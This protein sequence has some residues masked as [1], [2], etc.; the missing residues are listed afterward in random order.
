MRVLF[1]CILF[2]VVVVCLQIFLL[3]LLRFFENELSDKWQYWPRAVAFLSWEPRNSQRR[4]RL[5]AVSLENL[6][7]KKTRK[8]E[9]RASWK[10]K[11]EKSNGCTLSFYIGCFEDSLW[12]QNTVWHV[13]EVKNPSRYA[14]Q[15]SCD[16]N[17]TNAFSYLL[18]TVSWNTVVIILTINTGVQ[19]S[20]SS[21]IVE[22]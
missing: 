1:C 5:L 16:Q 8:G 22:Q 2:L 12:P 9:K 17:K 3:V 19:T 18:Q 21:S 7:S 4:K 14:V 10:R 15:Q 13:E 20:S 11:N 6:T